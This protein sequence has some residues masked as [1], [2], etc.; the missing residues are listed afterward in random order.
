M[1]V[2]PLPP[3]GP[4][5]PPRAPLTCNVIFLALFSRSPVTRLFPPCRAR[6]L[7]PGPPGSR[8]SPGRWPFPGAPPAATPPRGPP[9]ALKRRLFI[10]VSQR[11]TRGLRTGAPQKAAIVLVVLAWGG[12]GRVNVYEFNSSVSANNGV[13]LLLRSCHVQGLRGGGRGDSGSQRPHSPTPPG[14]T[15]SSPL[16]S[17]EEADRGRTLGRGSS[18]PSQTHS[19]MLRASTETRAVQWRQN[20]NWGLPPVTVRMMQEER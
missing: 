13:R 9:R 11:R 1:H 12:E 8:A 3:H 7:R 18:F 14:G 17:G 19:E 4:P 6:L 20:F 15:A 5:G 2:P 16:N 10:F